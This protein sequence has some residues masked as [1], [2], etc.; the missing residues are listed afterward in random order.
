MSVSMKDIFLLCKF[1]IK[2]FSTAE[3]ITLCYGIYNLKNGRAEI[4]HT[5]I[6]LLNCIS[7]VIF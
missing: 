3:V 2:I 1:H 4:E 5:V 6:R 7:D